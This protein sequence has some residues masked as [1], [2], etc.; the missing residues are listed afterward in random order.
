MQHLIDT[1]RDE[2]QRLCHQF[3]VQRLDL[4]GSAA[5]DSFDPQRSAATAA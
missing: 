2:V 3:G 1:H 4:F 5:D